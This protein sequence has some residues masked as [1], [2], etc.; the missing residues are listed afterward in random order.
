M[1]RH[2]F[3]SL[4]L[5]HGARTRPSLLLSFLWPSLPFKGQQEERPCNM[6]DNTA[7]GLVLLRPDLPTNIL[8]ITRL[9]HPSF[10]CAIVHK[11][12]EAPSSPDRFRLEWHEWNRPFLASLR[13]CVTLVKE[14]VPYR[15]TAS[16]HVNTVSRQAGLSH[17][18]Y[19]F[20]VMIN[21][22]FFSSW[23][24]NAVLY[25]KWYRQLTRVLWD[26]PFL[27]ISKRPHWNSR[28][29]IQD[30]AKPSARNTTCLFP[31]KTEIF[32]GKKN[33]WNFGT[34]SVDLSANL[35]RKCR[36]ERGRNQFW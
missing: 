17:V 3:C 27:A 7:G 23:P 18:K 12:D 29:L 33:P 36:I 28:V 13:E 35:K 5:I 4:S 30:K 24:S 6:N 32:P 19:C 11:V 14:G 31:P 10:F 8:S 16:N 34:D 2:G 26:H 15:I 1:A 22:M 25:S 20:F 21:A 9:R